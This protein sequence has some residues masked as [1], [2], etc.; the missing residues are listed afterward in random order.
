MLLHKKEVQRNMITE[1]VTFRPAEGIPNEEF[2]LIIDDLEKNFHSR[3]PGFIDTE[4]LFDEGAGEWIMIQHWD[5]KENQKSASSK[6]FKADAAELFVK[7]V[8][9]ASV[10]M[11]ILQQINVWTY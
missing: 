1:I 5:T 6:I 7:S 9:P 10:K 8:V 11:R 3:Q 4:L 2:I